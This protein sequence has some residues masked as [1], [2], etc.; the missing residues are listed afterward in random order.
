LFIFAY[1]HYGNLNYVW[2]SVS[3][4][5]PKVQAGCI[6]LMVLVCVAFSILLLRLMYIGENGVIDL[7]GCSHVG[8]LWETT[9]TLNSDG[10]ITYVG[11][12]NSRLAYVAAC[13]TSPGKIHRQ[14]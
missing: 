13:V 9:V 3:S 7:M 1:R 5:V 14:E 6:K 12:R 8:P 2:S 10:S 4:M 11:K